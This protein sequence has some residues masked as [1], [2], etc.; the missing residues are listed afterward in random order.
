MPTTREA[1]T[2]SRRAMR[3]A[4]SKGAPVENDLQQH[5][6]FISPHRSRQA[7]PR[8]SHPTVEWE[9]ASNSLYAASAP[10]NAPHASALLGSGLSATPCAGTS[11]FAR[12]R[13]FAGAGEA[14]PETRQEAS[15]TRG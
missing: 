6:Q 15:G 7:C 13:G 12:N 10:S 1:S 2:P 9:L 5:P 8:F 11:E 3:K 14:G 4:E